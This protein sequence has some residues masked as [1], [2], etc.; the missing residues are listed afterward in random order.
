MRRP[1]TQEEL[2]QGALEMRASEERLRREGIEVVDPRRNRLRSPEDERESLQEFLISPTATPQILGPSAPQGAMV[3]PGSEVTGEGDGAEDGGEKVRRQ[4]AREEEQRMV[5]QEG[6]GGRDLEGSLSVVPLF[7]DQQ[8]LQ[9][10]QMYARAPLLQRS[11]PTVE[12]PQWMRFEDERYQKMQE[13]REREREELTKAAM[14]REFQPGQLLTRIHGLERQNEQTRRANEEIRSANEELRKERDALLKESQNLK[15][16]MKLFEASPYGTPEE[17][18]RVVPLVN[19]EVEKEDQWEDEKRAKVVGEGFG[20]GW[21]R[22]G[23]RFEEPEAFRTP[24]EEEYGSKRAESSQPDQSLMMKGMLKLMEGMQAL[25]T[26]IMSVKKSKDV[27]VVKGFVGELQKLPEWRADSAPLDLMD[28]LLSIGPMMGDLSDNSQTWWEQVLE[29]VKV[30]YHDHLE[31]SPLE[32]VA[33]RPVLPPE[34]CDARYLRLEKRATALLMQAIPVSQQ[35]EVIAG[36]E[37]T[38]VSILSRLMLSYQPGGL[39]EKAAILGAPDSPEEAQ[40]LTAAVSGL[41][42]WLRWHRRA[43]EVGVTRPDPTIQ[44]R[45]LSKL[46]RKVLRDNTDLGFRIS[47]AKSSLQV[48]T[49]PTESSVM[50][51][52]HHLLAE[53]EQIAHQD[54]KKRV[55]TPSSGDPKVKRFEEQG[56]GKGEGK[57]GSKGGEKGGTSTMPCK[58]F[59]SDE[60]CKKGKLCGWLHQGDD[61]RRC[62]TCGST[63][64]YSPACERPKSETAEKGGKSEGKGKINKVMKKENEEASSANEANSESSKSEA[65]GNEVMKELL[66]E[67]NKMIKGLAMKG[68]E[69]STGRSEEPEDRR[70]EAMQKQIDELK[71]IRVLRLT[72]LEKSGSKMGLLDSGATHALRGRREGEDLSKCEEVMVTL[73]NG[74]QV[75]MKMSTSGVM[76]SMDK[77]VE[78]IVPLGFLG[79]VLGYSIEWSGG[80]MTLL[81]PEKG[82]VAVKIINGCPQVRKNVAL[83]MIEEMEE[84]RTRKIKMMSYQKERDWLQ[85]LVEAHPILKGLP[86]WLKSRLPELPA[87]NLRRIPGCNRRKRKK[88]QEGFVAHLYA[89]EKE[90]Y[91]L[92]RAFKEVGG[93]GNKL[94]EIDVKRDREGEKLHDMLAEGGAYSSLLRA[95]IDG[96]LLAVVMGP[97]CR[98]RSVLRHYPLDVPGG[99]PRPLRTWKE[100]WGKRGL[101]KFEEDKVREDDVMLWR[102]IFLFIVAEE[103]R[104]ATEDKERRKKT[105][106]GLE[107]PADPS[108][109]MPE[110]VSFWGTNEWRKLKEMYG[111]EEQTFHQSSWGGCATKPTTFGGNLLLRLPEEESLERVDGGVV[112]DSKALARWAPGMMREVATRIQLDVFG[113][114][115]FIRALSWSEHLRRGHMP[116]RRDCQVCQEAS[117][118]ARR[119][120]KVSHPRAGILNLDVA[121][122]FHLGNDIE[123]QAKFMLLGTCTWLRPKR[124]DSKEDDEKP[125][126]KKEEVKEDA[127][128][129]RLEEIEEQDVEVEEEGPSLEADLEDVEEEAEDEKIEEDVEELQEGGERQEGEEEDHQGQEVRIDPEIEVIKVG[130]PIQGK[131]KEAAL[132]GMAELYMALRAEGFPI[133]TIHTDRGR[134]FV[135]GRVKAWMKSRNLSHSTN[136]GEDP[137]ANGRIERA[138][139]VIKSRVRRLLHGSKLEVKWWPMALRYAMESDRLERRGEGRSIPAFGSKVLVKKRNWRTKMMEPTHEETVYLTP[140]SQAHGH[141]VLRMNGRWGVAPYVIKNI[142]QPPPVE[143]EMWLALVD[144]VEKDEIEVRRR[145]R[146]KGPRMKKEEVEVLM[147]KKMLSEESSN[148]EEDTVENAAMMFKKTEVWRK[149]MKKMEE[150]EQEVLQTKIISPMEMTRDIALWDEAVRSELDSLLVTKKALKTISEEDKNRMEA[151]NVDITMVPSKLV[152]TRK[153]GGRRKVRI[154]A[155]GN[156]IEKGESEDLYA[157]GSD[158]ISMRLS[159]KKAMLEGWT[160]ASLDIKTAFLNAPLVSEEEEGVGTTAVV[161]KPPNILVKLGYVESTAY[162]KA[163]MA[164][165]GLRQSP[166]T[167]GDHRDECLNLMTWEVENEEFY[168]EPMI[169]EPNLW[170]VMKKE[171]VVQDSQRGLMLV[172]VD[173]LLILSEDKVVRGA[174]E[175]ISQR[176]EVSS[177]EWLNEENPTK[178]L[179]VEIW[180]FEEGIFV[181]QEKYLVDVLRRNGQ[182]EGVMS[183][184]PITKDQVQ[185]LEEEDEGKTLEEVRLAQKATGELMWMLTRSR[186][187]LMFALSKMSQSTLKSPKEVLKVAEQTW[188]YLRRTRKDGLWFKRGGGDKLEVFTD[189]SYG[190]GGLDSQGCVVVKFGGDVVMWKSGRQSIPSLSTAESELGEAIEGLTMG[191]SIDVLI[192]EMSEGS[193]EK[194]IKVDNTAAVSLLS[195]PAGSWR[196]RHLRLRAAHLRWRLGRLDW[197]VESIP[198]EEQVADIGTK[199][200]SSPKLETLKTM[201]N[202]GSA[203]LRRKKECQ[204]DEEAEREEQ[205]RKK[206]DGH[207]KKEEVLEEALRMIVMAALIQGSRAQDEDEEE[208][209]GRFI[210]MVGL[211]MISLSLVGLWVLLRGV[212]KLCCRMSC[213][214]T[215]SQPEEEPELEEEEGREAE[216]GEAQERGRRSEEHEE[217]EVQRRFEEVPSSSTTLVRREGLRQRPVKGKGKGREVIQEE[218]NNEPEPLVIVNRWLPADQ[219]QGER[220][221]AFITTYGSKW[222]QFTTCG[223]LAQRSQPLIASTWCPQCAE[224]PRRGFVPVF[225]IGR[226]GMVHY[227]PRCTMLERDSRCFQKCAMCHMMDPNR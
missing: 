95:A 153:A 154:V 116:F 28:W 64:H 34:L 26:E 22:E 107:Q 30:W 129:L 185:R 130:I 85:D 194:T 23:R 9:M 218:R 151:E 191:D 91:D 77:D 133:H 35:E 179:G 182:E 99:G 17:S 51:F 215:S 36:K 197:L 173:D 14:M 220:G 83:R 166:K 213:G 188:K 81:H 84:G 159:L 126:P 161:L 71:K 42:K 137:K 67:A 80:V 193:Y 16:R 18:R 58:F 87:D 118:I 139:G 200:L 187:D 115:P 189:S 13:E 121:G 68:G 43:G 138:V 119:H 143:E 102:G 90:G 168:F 111:L 219:L 86:G 203:D 157:S 25:Q 20:D 78:P 217:R 82:R 24:G 152:I 158:S 33:H 15:E 73:A 210:W 7:S 4:E 206:D 112:R 164:M 39:S 96:S 202:M 155:C 45:G 76:I 160:G 47:L 21:R 178:F 180:E 38:V 98:T 89:G 174:I 120:Q 177:P 12:R 122:P 19:Q 163:L 125:K 127:E 114:Q 212:L 128:E 224:I 199:V 72:K 207:V 148:I 2:A 40:S 104:K 94:V 44:A 181:N 50:K 205:K 175:V 145:I 55:E 27:E 110:V 162:W 59:L 3:S 169:S 65:G 131:T 204:K 75:P 69:T 49:T 108:S 113:S 135:N 32:R 109:Y 1:A 37:V 209:E 192:Q 184:I 195:E 208:L 227:D 41:R 172:Y 79:G 134:E 117:G 165:Y 31:L 146:G 100:P 63:S 147:I 53:T 170:R 11:E 60:G 106:I 167:W 10:E 93:D 186:P 156:Y 54:R 62:W 142:Q 136:A 144:E 52:A 171:K 46:M 105:K 225:G 48:D 8:I 56:Q 226:G 221:P 29:M 176:W 101:E 6:S 123:V 141:C 198:G 223:P 140:V 211:L 150:E 103:V 190:P 132:E 124:Q 214:R 88:M 66:A 74:E 216:G 61:K 149:R 92:G 97:N 5:E 183:G 222:H 201:M 70:I 57:H 196:T